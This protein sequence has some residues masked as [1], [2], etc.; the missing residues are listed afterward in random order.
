MHIGLRRA[1]W[2][3]VATG[4]SLGESPHVRLRARCP[5][6]PCGAFRWLPPFRYAFERSS[7]PSGRSAAR[8]EAKAATT[9]AP[10]LAIELSRYNNRAPS[11]LGV[12][13]ANFGE[14]RFIHRRR[15]RLVERAS[16]RFDGSLSTV[17]VKR[18][19]D[20]CANGLPTGL[21]LRPNPAEDQDAEIPIDGDGARIDIA[22]LLELEGG[23][24]DGWMKRDIALSHRVA[25]AIEEAKVSS[26]QTRPIVPALSP[27]NLANLSG[28]ERGDKRNQLFGTRFALH[29]DVRG[30]PHFRTLE[31]RPI[32]IVVRLDL[33]VRDG[34]F[35]E[36]LVDGLT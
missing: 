15:G 28:L 4:V 5:K 32:F 25:F 11:S 17:R 10:A 30:A 13:E 29:Q 12:I 21:S 19:L 14:E 24:R 18:R 34:F 7:G 33:L 6:L 9:S 26:A 23:G 27:D 36:R 8:T 20:A 35:K 16:E 22:H 3:F 31:L 1:G 2:A